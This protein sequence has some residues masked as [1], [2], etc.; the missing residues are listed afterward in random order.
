MY[1]NK[2][3]LMK[4]IAMIKIKKFKQQKKKKMLLK[5]KKINKNFKN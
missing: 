4:I 2:I 1:K 5:K 3:K